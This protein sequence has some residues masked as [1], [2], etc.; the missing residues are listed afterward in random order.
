MTKKRIGILSDI[1][2]RDVRPT[3]KKSD[4]LLVRDRDEIVGIFRDYLRGNEFR[5][6]NRIDRYGEFEFF[7]D[8]ILYL[9]ETVDN[10]LLESGYYR[11]ILDIYFDRKEAYTEF[12]IFYTK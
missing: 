8:L 9:R 4:L 1:L 11:H 5:M 6:Y 7:K 12:A 10:E 2:D 3:K